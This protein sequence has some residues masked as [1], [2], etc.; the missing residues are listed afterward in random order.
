MP[1]SCCSS[2][3]DDE[4]PGL[5]STDLLLTCFLKHLFQYTK[6]VNFSSRNSGEIRFLD[7]SFNFP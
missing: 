3:K 7:A 4:K 1:A 6:N 2:T 5:S